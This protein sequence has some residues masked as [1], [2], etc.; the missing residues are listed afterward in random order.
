MKKVQ[1]CCIIDD[2]PIFIYGTKRIIEKV[3]FCNKIIVYNNGQEAIDGIY[4]LIKTKEQLP[5]VILLDINM[6]VMDGWE[7]LVEFKKLQNLFSK[8]IHI[9]IASSSVDPR[10]IERVKNYKEVSDYILKPIT[11]DDLGKIISATTV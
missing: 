11:P 7:F 8:K 10:D 5:D 3:D 2:D 1:V 4:E 6:P 9:Y